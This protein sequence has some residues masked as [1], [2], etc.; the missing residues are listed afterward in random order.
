MRVSLSQLVAGRAKDTLRAKPQSLHPEPRSPLFI[1]RQIDRGGGIRD[2]SGANCACACVC[3]LARLGSRNENKEER[4]LREGGGS[5]S[6]LLVEQLLLQRLPEVAG[7]GRQGSK[8]SPGVSDDCKL[9][10][11]RKKVF[12]QRRRTFL[13]LPPANFANLQTSSHICVTT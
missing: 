11:G 1:L 13:S 2:K 10:G 4:K 7:R 8:V 6:N 9:A 12:P 5:Q 3:V